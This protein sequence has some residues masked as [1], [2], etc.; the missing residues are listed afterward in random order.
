MYCFTSTV[1]EINIFMHINNLNRLPHRKTTDGRM[2]FCLLGEPLSN[3][4]EYLKLH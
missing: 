4:I 3:Q 1:A 2:L